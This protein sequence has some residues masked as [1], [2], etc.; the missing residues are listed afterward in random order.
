[1]AKITSNGLLSGIVGPVSFRV[2]DGKPFV[3]ARPGKGGVRQTQGTKESASE[4]G[5]ASA[6]A[7]AIR[8]ALFPI[9]QNHCDP[10]MH[11]RFSA[12]VFEAATANTGLTHGTRTLKDGDLSRLNHFQFN[13]NCLFSEY[14]GLQ[15]DV[16]G[17]ASGQLVVSLP[18]FAP[19]TMLAFPADASGCEICFM[20]SVFDP[21]SWQLDNA[22]V[23]KVHVAKGTAAIPAQEFLSAPIA[24]GQAVIVTA[25]ILYYRNNGPM[26]NLQLNSATLHPC[27]LVAAFIN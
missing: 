16:F 1:M 3:Q 12:K 10:K 6:T 11:L 19:T 21:W 18:E 17:N 25:A 27:E 15:P 13:S 4:F 23:F 26:G 9:L 24:S 5:K 14:C 8:L 20:V 7:K 22:E 2:R